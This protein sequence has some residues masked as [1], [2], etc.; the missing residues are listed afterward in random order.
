M[1]IQDLQKIT[2]HPIINFK[3]LC[4]EVGYSYSKMFQAVQNDRPLTEAESRKI[5]AYL[6][7]RG[8]QWRDLI[9]EG[10]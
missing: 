10:L 1:T 5:E 9:K 4:D 3:G 7:T 8:I 6:K 2:Q